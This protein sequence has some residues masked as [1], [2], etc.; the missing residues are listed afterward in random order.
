MESAPHVKSLRIESCFIALGYKTVP[1]YGHFSHRRNKFAKRKKIT[2][3]ERGMEEARIIANQMRVKLFLG[4]F[5]CRKDD[6]A[7]EAAVIL[8]DGKEGID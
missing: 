3:A 2:K 4:E 8:A 6:Q 5:E 7:V 1:S